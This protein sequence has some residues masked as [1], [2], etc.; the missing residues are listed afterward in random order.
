MNTQ[1]PST[2]GEPPRDEEAAPVV[3]EKRRCRWCDWLG[4]VLLLGMIWGIFMVL[5]APKCGGRVDI[6][7]IKIK[8]IEQ[9]LYSYKVRVGE[10]PTQSEGL[11]VLMNPPDGLRPFLKEVPKDSCGNE[12]LYFNPPRT[13]KGPFEVASMGRDGEL[14]T[15]DDLSS[16][17]APR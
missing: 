11:G 12:L 13:G 10:Y 17:R 6:T 15:D 14:G 5:T 8:N 2:H 1:D 3:S 16:Q 4:G 7:K 9:G